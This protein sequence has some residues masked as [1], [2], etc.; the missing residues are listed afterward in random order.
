VA[1]TAGTTIGAGNNVNIVAAS[2]KVDNTFL[3]NE[4]TSGIFCGGSFG[5]SI[6]KQQLPARTR[7]WSMARIA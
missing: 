7:R 6:G 2:D 4:G 3:R 1:S 5:V